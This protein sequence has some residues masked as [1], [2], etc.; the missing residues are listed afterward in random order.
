MSAGAGAGRLT[1]ARW[2]VS[3]G[4]S[5]VHHAIPSREAFTTPC[6]RYIMSSWLRSHFVP[7]KNIKLCQRCERLEAHRTATTGG[8]A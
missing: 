4:R 6:G 3:T 8:E 2:F 5:M 7:N 1:E